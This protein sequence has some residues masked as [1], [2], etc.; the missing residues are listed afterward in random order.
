[1]RWVT[2]VLVLLL[3]VPVALLGPRGSVVAL[4]AALFVPE[5]F[6]DAPVKPLR[7]VTAPSRLER[8]SIQYLG[9]AARLDTYVPVQAGPHGGVILV[10]GA[11]PV[12]QDDPVVTNFADGLSRLGVIVQVPA[13]DGLAAGRID[14]SEVDLLVREYQ[15]LQ[16]RPDVDRKRVGFIGLSVGASLSLI[17]AADP[18]IAGDV[19]FVNAFGGYFD[20]RDLLLALA[21]HSL[22]YAG[23]PATWDPAPL[24]RE[25]LIENLITYLPTAPEREL[26][27]A[28][29]HG[30][31]V[32]DLTVLSPTARPVAGLLDRPSTAEARQL[33]GALTAEQTG[34]LDS[35]SPRAVIHRVQTDVLLMHDVN[36]RYVPF[37]ESRRLAAAL[38]PGRL[39]AHTEMT[40]FDH[41][42]PGQTLAPDEFLREVAGLTRHIYLVCLEML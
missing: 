39:R 16:S 2:V 12:D 6:P 26:V 35:I 10:L 14:P 18:R 15:A 36:D 32:P 4:K 41:V 5:I 1:M 34:Y 23:K 25:V 40:L 31:S 9:G 11:R 20:A 19:A 3:A 38:S 7:L 30:D 13:S 33:L 27:R 8:E 42:M 29:A 21:T 17:A 28:A 22:E 37:T 24:T